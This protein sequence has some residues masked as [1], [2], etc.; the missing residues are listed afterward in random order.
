MTSKENQQLTTIVK[1]VAKQLTGYELDDSFKDD[2]GNWRAGL[3]GP[4]G[5]RIVF[6]LTWKRGRLSIHATVPGDLVD[7]TCRCG[8]K[9]S[10]GY[11]TCYGCSQASKTCR[12]CGH[13]ERRN[14][15]GYVEGDWVR[16]GECQSCREER[17][18]G[19]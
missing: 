6:D 5:A 2:V 7:G 4:D 10:P 16:G 15:R 17:K 12:V 8:R 18:M 1:Q 9:C 13:V 19:Y 14:S 3:R 11:S